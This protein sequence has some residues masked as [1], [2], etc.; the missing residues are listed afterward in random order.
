MATQQYKFEIGRKHQA[1]ILFKVEGDEYF[2]SI[3][4]YGLFLLD[5]SNIY[6]PV[7][8]SIETINYIELDGEEVGKVSIDGD[9]IAYE[10]FDYEIELAYSN[11]KVLFSSH[12]FF[13]A[14]MER[15]F[16]EN[17]EVC[18]INTYTGVELYA[19]YISCEV[20]ETDR[21]K[22]GNV[23]DFTIIKVVFRVSKPS[24]C[25]FKKPDFIE[26][27]TDADGEAVLKKI[28][29]LYPYIDAK[30]QQ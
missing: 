7:P 5:Q 20:S 2:H 6:T 24:K 18:I 27:L 14:S 12:N 15:A 10:P 11:D 17:K 19:R 4:S 30:I 1:D 22:Y 8:K 23:K 29:D 9:S 26:E 21:A 16:K 13:V 25:N 28:T 3:R